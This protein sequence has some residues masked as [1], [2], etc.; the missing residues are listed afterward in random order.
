[1]NEN[2]ARMQLPL[3]AANDYREE[4]DRAERLR[5][6]LR[7]EMQDRIYRAKK[8]YGLELIALFAWAASM[9]IG[10][11]LTGWIVHSNTQKK[12]DENT[13]SAVRSAV[14]TERAYIFD[15]ANITQTQFEA[16]EA[17]KKEGQP[18]IL[19]GEESRQAAIEALA[20]PIAEHI[21]GLCMDRG[22][23]VDGVKTYIW[24]VDF[25][26]L[27]SGNYGRTIEAVLGG[28]VEGYTKG[29]GTR[30]EDDALAIELCTAYYNDELP[31]RWT[32][33]LE[34]ATINAD[35]SVTA[36]NELNTGS[37]TKYWWW[38]E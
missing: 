15:V 16:M 4:R 7:I 20:G 1:M 25:A 13:Q 36:R 26:R 19:T 21:A 11:C 28:T 6:E 24:G 18:H 37:K 12:A 27:K 14:A 17:A 34:F 32:P 29:H 33:D 8:R 5:A 38:E 31:R 9:M 30:P 22:V 3:F 2:D 23:T 35:G 10:C